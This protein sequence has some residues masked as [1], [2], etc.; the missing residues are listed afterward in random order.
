MPIQIGCQ[1][2]ELEQKL[3]RA[4][5]TETRKAAWSEPSHPMSNQ[6]SMQETLSLPTIVKIFGAATGAVLVLIAIAAALIIAAVF[7]ALKG[8]VI[9]MATGTG[10]V[11]IALA[12]TT[13][14][15]VLRRL[16]LPS[17]NDAWIFW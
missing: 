7:P 3:L 8:H 15:H 10:I 9:A 17:D 4:D 6:S 12:A 1:A 13:V 14:R 11:L 5:S 2:A 16:R